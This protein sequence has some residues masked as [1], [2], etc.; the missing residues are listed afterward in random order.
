MDA[1]LVALIVTELRGLNFEFEHEEDAAERILD[2]VRDR[3]AEAF[4]EEFCGTLG[5]DGFLARI[6]G[7]GK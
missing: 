5:A 6:F 1:K 4:E 3:V 2:I 7:D